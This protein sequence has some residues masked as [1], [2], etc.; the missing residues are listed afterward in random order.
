ML[1]AGAITLAL[2]KVPKPAAAH[3]A[4][5]PFDT[6]HSFLQRGRDEMALP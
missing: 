3:H 5:V 1:A 4:A 6:L 2:L